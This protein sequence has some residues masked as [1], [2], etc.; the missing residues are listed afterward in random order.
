MLVAIALA[1]RMARAIWA[2]ATKQED[3]RDPALSLAA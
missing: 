1:N 3:Y 2:M